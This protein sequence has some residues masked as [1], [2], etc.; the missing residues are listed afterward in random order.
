MIDTLLNSNIMFP[1]LCLKNNVLVSIL[2]I[3]FINNYFFSNYRV[4][5]FIITFEKE[6]NIFSFSIYDSNIRI[7]TSNC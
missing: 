4:L 1:T 2:I 6:N 5:I 3:L 7:R